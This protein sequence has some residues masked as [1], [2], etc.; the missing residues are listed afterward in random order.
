MIMV[1]LKMRMIYKAF[2]TFIGCLIMLAIGL[3]VL[4]YFNNKIFEAESDI[5]VT[6]ELSINYIDGKK[7]SVDNQNIIKFSVTNSS[8][9]MIFYNIGFSKVRGDGTYK[10][11][12]ND[13][14]VTE[15]KLKT[16][17]EITTDFISIEAGE[18][19][20]YSLEI[21]NKEGSTL[22]GTLNIRIKEGT[23]ITFADTI[24]KNSV[25]SDDSLSKV[26][27]VA[28]IDDEGLIKSSDDTGVSYYFR[29]NVSNNYVLFG[30][31]LWR[32][33]RINGDGTVRLVLDKTTDTVSSYYTS[34]NTEF[35]FEKS[36]INNY[37][38]N[39]LQDNLRNEADYIANSKF[40]NDLSY[41]EGY[42]YLA[43]IRIMTNKIPTLNCL[44]DAFNNNIGL[45]TID[46]VMLAGASPDSYNKSFYL[47]NPEITESWYTM[48]GASGSDSNINMFM[49]SADGSIK[50]DI[51]GNLYR[52]VRP[53]INLIKNIEMKGVGTKE[54]PYQLVVEN[55]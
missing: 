4:Y 36:N 11:L 50:T 42:N 43:Y 28:A 40:C 45:L 52:N 35:N 19:K 24:L 34:D 48:T 22:T 18:T 27:Y 32:I 51:S 12:N 46:E 23:T 20:I 5:E 39:W 29:G 3:G 25:P 10:L 55:Q 44:G 1:K 9:S 21:Y 47:Y 6:G 49:I 38:E 26:G 13:L 15:G 16:V 17:D 37:L 2:L 8:D 33:V 41:D 30:N 54:M 31:L 14:V 53:V 7:I